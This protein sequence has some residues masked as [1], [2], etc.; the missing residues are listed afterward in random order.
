LTSDKISPDHPTIKPVSLCIR[1]IRNS[2]AKNDI[3]FDP[4][5]GSG[6]TLIAAEKLARRCF[7]I[8]LEPKYCDV[9]VRRY[10]AAAGLTSVSR[11]IADRYVRKE[12]IV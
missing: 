6:S 9:I 5:L 11:R 1:A 8:E 7:G 12:A 2:S 10:I 4:F 3:V